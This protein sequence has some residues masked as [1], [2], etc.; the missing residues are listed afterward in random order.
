MVYDRVD[1]GGY[2]LKEKL[3]SWKASFSCYQSLKGLAGTDPEIINFFCLHGIL[4]W[5]VSLISNKCD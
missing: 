1:D 3:W 5:D 2:M 4:A